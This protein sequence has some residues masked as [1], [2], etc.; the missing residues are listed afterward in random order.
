MQVKAPIVGALAIGFFAGGVIGYGI[1]GS[2]GQPQ[3]VADPDTA[4]IEALERR[5]EQVR[6]HF[7]ETVK[8]ITGRIVD[9]VDG[10]VTLTDIRLANPLYVFPERVQAMFT[11]E[12]EILMRSAKDAA[13]YAV[14]VAEYDAAL[15]LSADSPPDAPVIERPNPFTLTVATSADLILSM[16]VTVSAD[17]I[18]DGAQTIKATQ[19]VFDKVI[20]V[21][22]ESVP[23]SDV[24]VDASAP[25][26]DPEL[27]N[28]DEGDETPPNGRNLEE[29]EPN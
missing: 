25:D 24:P 6:E 29:G 13:V 14:E 11:P 9:V 21:T 15:E 20:I 26:D 22:L 1:A 12:T 18:P 19:I 17:S 7:P 8:E 28:P 5:I 10:S 4:R 27:F 23:E 3:E 2:V 16:V